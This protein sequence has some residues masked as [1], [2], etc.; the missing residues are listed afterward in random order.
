MLHGDLHH[1]NIL[2]QGN[3]WLIIDPK[4]VIG[5]QAYEI[6]AFIRNPIPNLLSNDNAKDIVQDRINLFSHILNIPKTKIANWCFAQAV[7]AWIWALEDCCD[8]SYWPW[9]VDILDDLN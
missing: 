7:L 2:Q 3:D 6:A 5:E 1:D 9:L 8:T 4:G